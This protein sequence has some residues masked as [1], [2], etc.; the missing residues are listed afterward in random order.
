MRAERADLQRLDGK[1]EVVHRTGGTGE[2]QNAVER[3]GGLDEF[4]D[5][6]ADELKPGVAGQVR[7]VGGIAGEVVVDADDLVAL[8]QQFVAEM[9][10]EKPRRPGYE[11][12]HASGRPMLS[13]VKPSL[14]SR[15]G[16]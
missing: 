9:R 4:G 6:V 8:A 12:A 11:E 1:L 7:E 13:Y 16:S 14:A 5:G 10:A 3:A 15:A 2:V